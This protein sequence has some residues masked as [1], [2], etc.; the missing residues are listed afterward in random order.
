MSVLGEGNTATSMK[1][2]LK[3]E[4]LMT[5]QL[6]MF[7]HYLT[8]EKGLS[9]NTLVS[10][11]RDLL[12]FLKFLENSEIKVLRDV[13]RQHIMTY[14]LGLKE[15]GKATSTIS[16]CMASI[17]AF[18]QYLLRDSKI[19]SDP[20]VHLETPRVERR[21]PK[22]LSISEVDLLLQA[23]QVSTAFGQRDSAMLELLYATGIRVS[24]MVSLNLDD[25]HLQMGFI[26]CMGKG[27]KERI[28]PLGGVAI[29]AVEQYLQFGRGP[30]S[31][32]K[33]TT[34]LFL[35]HHGNAISRQGF[36]KIIKK[37]TKEAG[38]QKEI[39]PH[40]LRHSFATH[41]LE[42]GAD[43]RSV[44]EMLGHADISTTQIYTHVTKTRLR[45]VYA[46]SHPRA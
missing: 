30:L 33:R 38:I 45:D 42:N 26:K 21:L 5:E 28:I 27:S 14:L 12:P 6:Q 31:K 40:T 3:G 20:T 15:E 2:S 22:V 4:L 16:R 34:A 1:H 17:R 23:P 41:L 19:Q 25:V 9:K 10:Y 36:W 7:I 43:L 29:K 32:K 39:T 35:N 37:Y 24:E 46:K 13:N 44:Q 18:F 11:K 8:V